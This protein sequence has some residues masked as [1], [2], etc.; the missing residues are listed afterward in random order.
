MSSSSSTV[1]TETFATEQAV[2]AGG[3]RSD[4]GCVLLDLAQDRLLKLNPVAAA[5]WQ[6]LQAHEPEPEIVRALAQQDGVDEA[7][8]ARDVAALRQQLS[9]LAPEFATGLAAG[10]ELAGASRSPAAA[11]PGEPGRAALRPFY[12]QHGNAPRPTPPRGMVLAA[13]LG[14]AAF[15][16]VLTVG[17]LKALCAR[18]RGF[19][20]RPRRRPAAGDVV[21]VV[22]AA[23]DRACVWYPKQAL[24]LQR[25]AV[26]TCLLR[27]HGT[28]ARLVIGVRPMPFFAHAWVEVDGAVVN[29]WPRVPHFYPSLASY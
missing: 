3:G 1:P 23:V 17:S 22:C 18:V 4:D 27:R 24:C 21:G 9:D 13:L 25:S 5:I 26:T 15:D 8:V 2:T 10:L 29:D 20:V 12:G 28:P 11:A 19:A 16:L 7:R 14:L 6:R